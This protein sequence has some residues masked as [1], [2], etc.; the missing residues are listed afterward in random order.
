MK[1]SGWAG[2]PKSRID[3][4]PERNSGSPLP[5]CSTAQ[6]RLPT[7]Q[8]LGF[9]DAF[10][11]DSGTTGDGVKTS[12]VFGVFSRLRLLALIDGS[13]KSPGAAPSWPRSSWRNSAP[14][15]PCSAARSTP[16]PG[17]ACV[18][19]TTKAPANM[20]DRATS[21]SARRSWADGRRSGCSRA[22]RPPRSRR[23][24]CRRGATRACTHPGRPGRPPEQPDR[25]LA[26]WIQSR[27][28]SLVQEPV[29]LGSARPW[30]RIRCTA[31]CS[32]RSLAS[33]CPPRQTW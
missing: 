23:R 1:P 7:G 27:P 8:A 28:R 24:D 10:P 20:P 13:E 15:C 22:T 32:A 12:D 29:L 11:A 3:R 9:H 14:T 17:L 6:C 26:V 25:R 30:Y 33:R 4:L 31:A 19:A 2:R 21:I 16:R 5:S 18:R